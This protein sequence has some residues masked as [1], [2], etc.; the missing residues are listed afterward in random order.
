MTK[1][2]HID[3]DHIWEQKRLPHD[4]AILCCK[5]CDLW[6]YDTKTAKIVKEANDRV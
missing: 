2:I 1:I 3:H 4:Q 5:K 6:I